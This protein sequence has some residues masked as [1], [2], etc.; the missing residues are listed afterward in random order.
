[1]PD[2]VDA[3][4]CN[5]IRRPIWLNISYMKLSD[6]VVLV[7]FRNFVLLGMVA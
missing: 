6:E 1:M 5:Q 2:H 3:Y 7:T 4:M